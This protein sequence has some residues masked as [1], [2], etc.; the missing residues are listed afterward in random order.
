V[1][2]ADVAALTLTVIVPAHNEE[3]G[4]PETL[5]ALLKQ[6]MPPDRIIVVDD[7]SND[8]TAEVARGYPVEVMR[9]GQSS[10]SKSLALNHALAGCDTDIVMNVDGD[11]IVGP[12][13][14]ERIKV[15]FLDPEVAV[16]AGI[17]QVWN[18]RGVIQRGR[19][20]EYLL[21]QH[22]YRPIQNM[23]ASPTV[24][25]G[26][27]CAYRRSLLAAGGGFPD[28]TIA[29]DMDYTWQTMIAGYRAVYVAGAECYV[30]DPQ[31][32]GQLSIQL[33]RWMSG[34]FQCVRL[35][36][37]EILRHK[38]V[39]VLLVLASVWD[40]CSLPLWLAAPFVAASV[41][42]AALVKTVLFA[43][44]STDV[45]I[46]LPVVLTGAIRRGVSPLWALASL[47]CLWV[48]RA[49][50][51]WYSGKAMICELVLVPLGL[52]SSLAVFKKGH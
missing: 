17:V 12:D 24:C 50:N 15:P 9:R 41:L 22:L 26:A 42:G 27:A 45:L 2:T 31:T 14:V 11:T 3:A 46:T 1:A 23:W 18:P 19:E 35:H 49:F 6:T 13:F 44:L 30:I 7:G 37:K 38:R 4:L 10:G 34:Y 43:W 40:I 36:W 21:G 32:P 25:P 47:P 52:K 28:D 39:L 48:N 20:I 16:A 51:F 29:E 33:W 8:G 5:S